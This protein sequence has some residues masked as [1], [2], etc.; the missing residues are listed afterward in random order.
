MRIKKGLWGCLGIGLAAGILRAIEYLFTIDRAGYYL[1][2]P[3]A[4]FLSGALVGLLIAGFCWSLFCGIERGGEELGS[5]ELI[6]GSSHLQFYFMVV[7]IVTAIDGVGRIIGGIHIAGGTVAIDKLS[8]IAGLACL[9]GSIGWIAASKARKALGMA[10]LLPTIQIVVLI[11]VYFWTTYKEIHISGYILET[12]ALCAQSL[13]TLLVMK[14]MADA[15]TSR[16]RLARCCYWMLLLFPCA[17]LSP[18]L[19]MAKGIFSIQMVCTAI[20]GIALM[21]LS[22]QILSSL[23][24]RITHPAPKEQGKIPDEM[25]QFLSQ[26]PQ[27]DDFSL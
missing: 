24:W 18:L 22:V 27:D 15:T 17:N 14:M 3:T 6:G 8:I 13:I 9:L 25:E 21:L 10:A 7:G 23:H 2:G 12:L 26:L 16:A 19:R 5:K 4:E 11:I 20:N 1:P